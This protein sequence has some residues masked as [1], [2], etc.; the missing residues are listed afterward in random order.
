MNLTKVEFLTPLLHLKETN[1]VLKNWLGSTKWE[2]KTQ[3][4]SW[5]GFGKQFFVKRLVKVFSKPATF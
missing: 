3:S 2:Q 5:F 1:T 4:T